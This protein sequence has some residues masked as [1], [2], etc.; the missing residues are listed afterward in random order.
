MKSGQGKHRRECTAPQIN[1]SGYDA[2]DEAAN[3]WQPRSTDLETIQLLILFV[4]P[5]TLFL[6][7]DDFGIGRVSSEHSCK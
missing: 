6:S 7:W 1:G 2:D 5:V 3:F 4:L